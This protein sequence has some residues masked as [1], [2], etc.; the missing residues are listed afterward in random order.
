MAFLQVI[1]RTFGQRPRMLARNQASLA[2]LSDPDWE[3]TLVVDDVGRGINWANANLAEIPATGEYVWVLDDDDVCAL[4]ELVA[5]LKA[6]RGPAVI[7]MRAEHAF[8]GPLPHDSNW[9]QAPVLGD[10]GWSNFF[11]RGDVWEAQRPY[12]RQCDVYEGDYRWAAHL[13]GCCPDW[14]WHKVMAARYPQAS[15]GAAE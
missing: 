5:T 13:W 11:V 4:P 10:C 14:A 9:G 6:L 12:L 3:Q 15:R 7:V 8:F 1:T 2:S